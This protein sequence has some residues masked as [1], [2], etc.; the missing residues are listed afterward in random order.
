MC[1]LNS[2][3]VHFWPLLFSSLHL[4]RMSD[5]LKKWRCVYYL[6]HCGTE[7]LQYIQALTASETQLTYTVVPENTQHTAMG[8]C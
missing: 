7:E 2:L 8:G 6:P 1:V 4:S 3:P 5:A